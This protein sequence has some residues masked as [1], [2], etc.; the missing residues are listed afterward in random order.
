MLLIILLSVLGVIAYLTTGLFIARNHA[1]QIYG[2]AK[3][4][5]NQYSAKCYR[6]N[7]YRDAVLFETFSYILFWL[8]ILISR[9]VR[10]GLHGFVMSP[11][12]SKREEYKEVKKTIDVWSDIL[13]NL[14]S[15]QSE[16]YAAILIIQMS[17]SKL[18]ELEK[19]K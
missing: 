10:G 1:E 16:K 18:K 11:I 8:P 14:D 15:S 6:I 3:A 17:E 19:F 13:S 7:A 2:I 4:E 9:K 5:M 12:D